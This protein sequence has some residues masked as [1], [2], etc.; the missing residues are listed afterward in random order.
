MRQ[1]KESPNSENQKKLRLQVYLAHA[2]VASRRASEEL[3]RSG[4][5]RVNGTIVTQMG[6][7]VET[8]DVVEFDG[9]KVKPN[10]SKVYI[11]LHKPSGYVSTV[12]DPQGRPVILDLMPNNIAD[13]LYPI[14]RLD[15]LS[16]GL[17][18]CTNDGELAAHVMHPSS[19]IEKEYVVETDAPIPEERLLQF[20]RGIM[21]EGVQ[22]RLR[23]Y[24]IRSARRVHLVLQEGKNRELR[25]V[26]TSWGLEPRRVHRVRIADVHIGKLPPGGYRNL[27]QAEIA[28]LMKSSG[29]G[30]ERP[31]RPAQ[32]SRRRKT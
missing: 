4:R 14:G 19:N 31:K 1:N 17:L 13:R 15:L 6:V 5:V 20:R 26:F 18:L 12:S 7:V 22:Y 3:I 29:A 11:A 30:R 16:T 9:R 23:H 21:I 24:Q 10:H 2:G 27:T 32:T 25:R 28:S 8:N